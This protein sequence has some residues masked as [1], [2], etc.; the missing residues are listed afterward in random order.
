MQN[1]QLNPW[2]FGGS[3]DA[4]GASLEDITLLQGGQLISDLSQGATIETAAIPVRH[5]S[6]LQLFLSNDGSAALTDF[7]LLGKMH[8][9]GDWVTLINGATWNTLGNILIH[10]T[11]SA[12]NIPT[13][14]A[15]ATASAKVDVRGLW[16]VKFQAS[17]GT[18][19][20]VNVSGQLAAM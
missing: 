15:S 5:R 20:E 9:L 12:G 10:R 2:Q 8:P 16:A 13:L 7:A 19:T 3:N 4:V 1:P 14:G 17:C 11:T 18:S 6:T